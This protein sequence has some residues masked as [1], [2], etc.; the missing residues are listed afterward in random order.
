MTI[1]DRASL[2]EALLVLTK[3]VST[4]YLVEAPRGVMPERPF[5]VLMQL[6]ARGAERIQPMR[7]RPYWRAV[8]QITAVTDSPLEAEDLACRAAEACLS[9]GSGENRAVVDTEIIE[10]T[11]VTREG[12][13]YNCHARVAVIVGA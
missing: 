13:V 1:I 10:I 11:Q 4:S 9:V 3:T 2:T 7:G 8:Y 5:T 6:G 12:G